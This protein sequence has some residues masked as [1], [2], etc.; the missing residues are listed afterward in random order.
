MPRSRLTRQ[1][2]VAHIIETFRVHGADGTSISRLTRA[3][4]LSKASL[5]HHFPKG[6]EEMLRTA[7]QTEH[8]RMEHE[9]T[10]HLRDDTIAPYTRLARW[11]EAL[12]AY[13]ADSRPCLFG[14]IARSGGLPSTQPDLQK[15]F[16]E[17]L[18]ALTSALTAAGIPP[19]IA[20]SRAAAAIERVQGALVIAVIY[21]DTDA[22]FKATR[23]LPAELLRAL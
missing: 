11:T 13:Y 18:I 9:V 22:I 6:K 12:Q 3:T 7:I 20:H 19:Q 1:Q 17:Q 21:T 15:V 10:A 5:Y 16:D 2:L 14:T 23:R 8:L 4:G